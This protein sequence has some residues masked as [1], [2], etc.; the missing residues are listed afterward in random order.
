[1]VNEAKDKN[2]QCLCLMRHGLKGQSGSPRHEAMIKGG[3]EQV[4][5]APV[6]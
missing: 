5:D 1:M 3:N 6:F 2:V 4:P